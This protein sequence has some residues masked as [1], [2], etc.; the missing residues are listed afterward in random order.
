MN[1]SMNV[2][3]SEFEQYE[4]AQK[5]VFNIFPEPGAMAICRW[6]LTKL[7]VSKYIYIYDNYDELKEVFKNG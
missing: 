6:K 3:K 4:L 2:S 7:T 5:K 1:F